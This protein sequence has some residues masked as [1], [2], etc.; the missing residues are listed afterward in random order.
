M[1]SI[2]K[3]PNCSASL[4][5]NASSGKVEC[6]YCGSSF[7]AETLVTSITEV[8]GDSIDG[9]DAKLV[10]D[11]TPEAEIKL[12]DSEETVSEITDKSQPVD[13][14]NGQEFVCNNCGARIVTDKNTSATFCMFCG[15]PSI[16]SQ[17]LEDEYSP[18]YIIPF[19]VNKDAAI[20]KFLDWC[21]GGRWSPF[22]FA[23][24]KNISKITGIYVPF[25]LY[26][27]V[28]DVDIKATAKNVKTSS[29]GSKTIEET[30]LYD[31]NYAK[32]LT[33]QDIPLDGSSALDDELM[34]AV[35]PFVYDE[36]RDFNP[37]Y[38]AGFFAERY[39]LAP[40]DLASRYEERINDYVKG[41][42]NKWSRN[43]GTVTM[44]EIKK[45]VVDSKIDYA[46]MPVWFLRYEYLSKA[47]YFAVNG[48]TGEVAGIVPKSRIK[49]LL[50]FFGVL[51]I[52][53]VIAR[54]VFG[55]MIGGFVG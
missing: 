33:Y 4:V 40:K 42:F 6:C 31:L 16:I 10:I 2:V 18:R 52:L 44:G 24:D 29:S 32:T 48:Q 26:S 1:T 45:R 25:W 30:I 14:E 54:F 20:T 22:G 21:Q 7:E 55:L 12:E 28:L 17:R 38:L 11:E 43:Y 49:R 37:M 39:D 53:A 23:S 19:K 3:C 36:L 51:A 13:S 5:F 8:D 46:L 27:Q 47:Y 41:D 15:S 50:V 35:E 9:T 34:E